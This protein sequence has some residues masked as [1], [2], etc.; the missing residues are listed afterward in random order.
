MSQKP[1][2]DIVNYQ[3]IIDGRASEFYSLKYHKEIKGV[4]RQFAE[5]G[6]EEETMDGALY[7]IKLAEQMISQYNF[8][9]KLSHYRLGA[10]SKDLT[11]SHLTSDQCRRTLLPGFLEDHE[12]LEMRLKLHEFA[13]N[14]ES[15]EYSLHGGTDPSTGK[16]S[17]ELSVPRLSR[18]DCNGKSVFEE[19]EPYKIILVTDNVE[20]ASRS[21]SFI[22]ESY[23]WR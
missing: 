22:L 13:E 2:E 16:Y 4:L 6:V 18:L 21:I 10:H 19:Q 23:I 17:I 5:L 7:Y 9:I 3:T 8:Y 1:A 20:K 15:L 12:R 11:L 14:L